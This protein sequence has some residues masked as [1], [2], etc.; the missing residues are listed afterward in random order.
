LICCPENLV[1]QCWYEC[2]HSS[3]LTIFRK[4]L[5]T[6]HASLARQCKRTGYC[7]DSSINSNSSDLYFQFIVPGNVAFLY[8]W[9]SQEYQIMC[10]H[11]SQEVICTFEDCS[12]EKTIFS[13]YVF[14]E[15]HNV[16]VLTQ[17]TSITIWKVKGPVIFNLSFS[18]LLKWLW[19]L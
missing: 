16:P 1:Y 12:N 18:F 13:M 11:L 4:L 2:W 14:G 5:Y 9:E 6:I 3:S 17:Y 15:R 8:F 7:N 10:V 19:T